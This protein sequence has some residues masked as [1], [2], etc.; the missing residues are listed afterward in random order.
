M[1]K[2]SKK[3]N[4]KRSKNAKRSL[5]LTPMPP[6]V[7]K[8]AVLTFCSYYNANEAA[9][10]AGVYNHYRLNGPYD[11]DTT[12]ASTATPGL[13][14]YASLY[15]RMRVYRATIHV[16]A[17]AASSSSFTAMISLVPNAFQPVLPANPTY[18]PVQR[19]AVSKPCTPALVNSAS[20]QFIG[21]LTEISATY[22]ISDVMNIT[23][24]QF[25]DEADYASTT[26]S[27]PTRQ[28]YVA[29]ALTTNSATIMGLQ[30]HVRISYDVEFFDPYPLQ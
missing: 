11:P 16:T 12:V 20:G 21:R 26:S 1:P 5:P 28:A 7:N 13:S 4:S 14:T 25:L 27:N 15:A 6:F 30:L 8:H 18:W 19:L 2:T 3:T 24:G 10:G 23:R 9:V 22:S 17:V 29:V